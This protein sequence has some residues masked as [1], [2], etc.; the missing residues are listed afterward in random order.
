LFDVFPREASLLASSMVL[1]AMGCA[2]LVFSLLLVRR[3]RA[4][5]K[6]SKNLRVGVFDKTF[7]V[8]DPTMAGRRIL[9][10]HTGLVVFLAIYGS[11]FAVT[12]GVVA[13]FAVGGVLGAVTFLVCAV[14]LMI[15]ETQELNKYAGVFAKAIRSGTGMGVGD[16]QALFVVRK[17]LPKLSRYHLALAIVFFACSVAVPYVATGVFLACAGLAW[18]FFALSSL[19]APVPLA[20]L[21]AVAGLFAFV[22]M[23]VEAGADEVKRVFFGFPRSIRLDVLDGQLERMKVYVRFQHHYPPLRVPEPED[24]EKVNRREIEEHGGS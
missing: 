15:D 19:L 1:V 21:L 7:N 17:A 5:G 24:T 14:L 22:I 10:S 23:V 4:L 6:V 2:A 11:W 13:T 18:A 20:S 3:S 9:S 16:L 12:A 8:F